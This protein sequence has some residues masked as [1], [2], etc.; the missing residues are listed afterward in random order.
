MD[1]LN[2]PKDLF[3]IGLNNSFDLHETYFRF[4]KS[5]KV[6]D[7]SKIKNLYIT[8]DSRYV[9]WINSKLISRGPSRSN[10][11]NQIIDVIDITKYIMEGENIICVLVYQPGY[12]HFS[13]IHRATS[14]LLAYFFYR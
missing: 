4:R 1:T 11:C 7:I 9:L 12:S 3:W 2:L 14:G 10:P 13:Y 6:K 5:F 8:A